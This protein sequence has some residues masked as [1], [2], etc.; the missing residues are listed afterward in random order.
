MA[1][2]A[3]QGEVVAHL[4]LPRAPIEQRMAD[5]RCFAALWS[6]IERRR[7]HQVPG[8]PTWLLNQGRQRLYG[9]VS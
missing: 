6:D 5:A 9:N 7:T 4:G 3:V 1:D 8:S 2:R